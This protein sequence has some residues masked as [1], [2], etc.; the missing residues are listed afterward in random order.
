MGARRER[1]SP[2]ALGPAEDSLNEQKGGGERF[3]GATVRERHSSL[4]KGTENN[5]KRS[6]QKEVLGFKERKN[7]SLE[8]NRN[9]FFTFYFPLFKYQTVT[10]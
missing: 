9:C 5:T 1:C 2:R 7:L 3:R 8:Q 10:L 6:M 4:L